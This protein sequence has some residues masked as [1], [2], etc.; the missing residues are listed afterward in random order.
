M[1]KL[2]KKFSLDYLTDSVSMEFD[3]LLITKE[4][5]KEKLEPSGYK[6]IRKSDL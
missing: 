3:P 1:Y 6:F 2:I 5:I 4:K